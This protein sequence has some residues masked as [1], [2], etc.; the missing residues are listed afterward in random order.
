[1]TETTAVTPGIP[2]IAVGMIDQPHHAEHVVATGLADVVMVGREL[3][4][5]PH[6][7]LR[8]AA[9]LH[10]EM[11]YAQQPYHHGHPSPTSAS[12]ARPPGADTQPRK[13]R[14]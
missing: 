6:F 12:P 8:A 4:R 11:P 14:S 5:D 1:V 13:D 3:L 10:L 9:A 2:A 7:P